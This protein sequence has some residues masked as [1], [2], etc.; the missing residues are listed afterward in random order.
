MIFQ[1]GGGGGGGGHTVSH[2][3]YLRSPLQ[4]FEFGSENGVCIYLGLEKILWHIDSSDFALL[5]N[6][7]YKVCS[8][9]GGGGGK[10]TANDRVAKHDGRLLGRLLPE[11][12]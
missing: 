10:V 8:G 9:G 5:R 1:R 12:S 3:E 2:P 6:L 11:G 4:M 7:N